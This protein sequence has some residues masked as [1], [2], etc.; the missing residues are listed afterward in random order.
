L[1]ILVKA[2]P[3][4]LAL[5]EIYIAARNCYSDMSPIE[6]WDEALR[7]LNIKMQDMYNENIEFDIDYYDIMMSLVTSCLQRGHLSVMEH[8]KITVS[9]S[10]ISRVLTHQLIRHRVASYSQ[11]S[12][13]YVTTSSMFNF[14]TP[15]E[16]ESNP[17]SN[18][19]YREAMDRSFEAYINIYNILYDK[20]IDKGLSKS[21]A[22]KKATEDARYV[23][24]NGIST[25]IVMTVN[26]REL[27][28]ICNE[29]L[30]SRAQWEI[31]GLIQSIADA[32][33]KKY[34]WLKP[35]LVAKC[36]FCGERN[37]CNK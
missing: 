22:D 25:N 18:K 28:H 20:Y 33:S 7:G 21:S 5:S 8:V 15:P 17:A 11:E 27:V 23:F 30:C 24:P 31:R 29:R 1:K 4:L 37:F 13:R 14:I 9:A 3:N 36:K 32:V 6:L 35:Y 12:Q 2:S 26:L 19:I 34:K 16:I 10:E